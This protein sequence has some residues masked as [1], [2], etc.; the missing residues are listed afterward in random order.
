L[1]LRE[2]INHSVQT[3]LWNNL[4]PHQLIGTP[5]IV[6]E[7]DCLTAT[8]DEIAI[9]HAN[10]TA[11]ITI[12]QGRFSGFAGWFDVHFRVSKLTLFL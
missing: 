1:D 8:L 4:H 11:S 5:F 2:T 3:S 6:K 7:M 9:V 10:F 12:E